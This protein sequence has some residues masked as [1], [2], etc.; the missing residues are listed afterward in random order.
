MLL[1]QRT[2]AIVDAK[3]HCARLE[4]R[5]VQKNTEPTQ[6]LGLT[7]QASAERLNRLVYGRVIERGEIAGQLSQ[8][9]TERYKVTTG[10]TCR[11]AKDTE[12][13]RRIKESGA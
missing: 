6:R 13:A 4:R 12:L 2:C 11:T 10:E 1:G 5:I 7:T 3:F 8:V 9:A